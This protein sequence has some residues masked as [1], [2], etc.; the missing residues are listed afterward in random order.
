MADHLGPWRCDYCHYLAHT[1][2]GWRKHL[3]NFHD[4]VEI[5]RITHVDRV[6]RGDDE[7]HVCWVCEAA[8]RRRTVAPTLIALVQHLETFHYDRVKTAEVRACSE[9][10]ERGF[11][12]L[13]AFEDY[14]RGREAA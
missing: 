13:L 3:E 8:G 4:G 12:R 5:R 2:V 14:Y 10:I 1:L 11:Y 7:P 9:R 6:H